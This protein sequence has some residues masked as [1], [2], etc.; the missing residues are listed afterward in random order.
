MQLYSLT[1]PSPSR[2]FRLRRPSASSPIRSITASLETERKTNME[3]NK[4]TTSY[5]EAKETIKEMFN[6]VELSVSAYDTAWVAMVPCL[7]DPRTPLY[8]K[9]LKWILENQLH[10]GSWGLPNRNPLLIKDAISSTLAC[11]LALKRWQIGEEQITKGLDFIHLNFASAMDDHSL[12]SPIGFDIIFPSMIDSAIEMAI[13]LHI[14]KKDLDALISMR[15]MDL[16]RIRTKN[17]DLQNLYLAYVSEGLGKVQDWETV[18]KFQRKNGSVLNSPSTTAF[19]LIN[20]CDLS[21]HKYLNSVLDRLGNAVPAVYPLDVFARLHLVDTLEKLGIDR[22]FTANVTTVLDEVFRLWMQN[23]EE[24]FADISTCSMAFR[25][26]RGHGYNVSSEPLAAYAKEEFCFDRFGGH[27]KDINDAMEVFKASQMIMYPGESFLDEQNLCSK[28]FLRNLLS[29]HQHMHSNDFHKCIIQEVQDALTN[30]IRSSLDRITTR[31]YIEHRKSDDTMILKTAYSF[32]NFSNE[33]LLKLAVEDFNYCQS[34]HGGEMKQLKRW[35]MENK[36]DQLTFSRQKTC[37]CYFS[38]ALTSFPPE[39]VDARLAWAKNAIL[40]TVVDDFFD[41]GSSLEEQENLINLVERWD[42]NEAIDCCSESV[43]TIFMALRGTIR[44]IAHGAYAWQDRNIEDHIIEIWLDLMKSMW[45]EAEM[46][47]NPSMPTLEDYMENGYVSFALGPI[48]LPT[49][50]LVAP[51]LSNEVI[52]SNECHKLFKLLSTTGRLLNDIRG[53][54]RET[55]Q[56]KVNSVSVYLHH[57]QGSIS[58]EE[59]ISELMLMA[60]SNRRQLFSL[61]L[62]GKESVVPRSCKD[63]FWKMSEVL[64]RF[65]MENDGFTAKDME[66]LVKSIV[67]DPIVLN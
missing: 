30:P 13:N 59:A 36:L 61:V 15:E 60:E 6:K 45:K 7:N 10:D 38:A 14:D 24:I 39:Y 1:I 46:T 63:L 11:V 44:E 26:L 54:E 16:K 21:C 4:R 58:K 55:S 52:R 47:R 37:Y 34:I 22:H 25:L 51:N 53:F 40:T 2:T 66:V 29:D 19:A 62:Q 57:H 65:Y 18:M 56:G 9:S 12:Y 33:V 41:V 50:Y 5:K 67:Q 42:E 27:L 8:P 43:R 49:L 64:Q 20:L 48:V 35:V 28:N 23:D 32:K 3:A 31:K 17:L